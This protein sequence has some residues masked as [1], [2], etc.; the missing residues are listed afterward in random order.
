MG[1]RSNKIKG[2]QIIINLYLIFEDKEIINSF[3]SK[4]DAEDFIRISKKYSIKTIQ[5]KPIEVIVGFKGNTLEQAKNTQ[6]ERIL[7]KNDLNMAMCV[8][9]G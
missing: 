9:Q 3:Y 1:R 6:I 8:W 4:S 2:E 5:I 7:V